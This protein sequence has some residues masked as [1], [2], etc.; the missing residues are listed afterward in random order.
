MPGRPIPAD[1]CRALF[2]VFAIYVWNVPW[3]KGIIWQFTADFLQKVGKWRF[4]RSGSPGKKMGLKQIQRGFFLLVFFALCPGFLLGVVDGFSG[5][6]QREKEGRQQK[7]EGIQRQG[8]L[9]EELWGEDTFLVSEFPVLAK[10][11]SKLDQAMPLTPTLCLSPVTPDFP[12]LYPINWNIWEAG[13]AKIQQSVEG[14]TAGGIL[15]KWRL[16]F[17]FCWGKAPLCVN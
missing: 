13:M 8:F 14:R 3:M 4:Q 9:S 11:C 12:L 15:Q 2:I 7:T 1:P 17:M 10:N 16:D 5:W 6:K